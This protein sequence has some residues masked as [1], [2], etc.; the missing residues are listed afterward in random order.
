MAILTLGKDIYETHLFDKIKEF[1]GGPV[2]EFDSIYGIKLFRF[3]SDKFDMN[4]QVMA[5]FYMHHGS[6]YVRKIT[7]KILKHK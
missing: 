2:I 7:N 1:I 3:H 4:D 5:K 6:I